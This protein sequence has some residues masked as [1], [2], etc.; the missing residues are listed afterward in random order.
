MDPVL[1][2]IDEAL[3][4]TGRSAADVSREAR[5]NP[6]VIKN[7]RDQ[8]GRSEKRYSFHVLKDLADVLGLELYFGPPRTPVPMP[9]DGDE[10]LTF[11]PRYD[12]SAAAG[13]GSISDGEPV[14][15]YLAFRADWLRSRGL[16]ASETALV[17][18]RGLSMPPLEDG[19]VALLD[20]R[21]RTPRPE[22]MYVFRDV[23]DTIRVKQIVSVHDALYFKST[24]DLY[25]DE[26]RTGADAERIHIIGRVVW[27]ARTIG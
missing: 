16:V 17:D 5:G 13:P 24:S 12:V 14:K 1:D 8:E 10:E 22:E 15:S 18:I 26:K 9:P 23:D 7:L 21:H 27:F 4:R 25:E 6:S 3:R 11:V 19:D 20:L 2:V